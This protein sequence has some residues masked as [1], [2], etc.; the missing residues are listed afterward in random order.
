MDYKKDGYVDVASVYQLVVAGVLLGALML[1]LIFVP[2]LGG[3][4]Y[5]QTEAQITAISDAN[6]EASVKATALSGFS[7]LETF[8]DYT[9][10]FVLGI[11]IVALLSLIIGGLIGRTGMG[12]A[13]AGGV[14]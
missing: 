8:S 9:G 14:L 4:V 3:A 1:V 11:I 6:V 10:L 13:G 5:E 7:T 12:G 2:V